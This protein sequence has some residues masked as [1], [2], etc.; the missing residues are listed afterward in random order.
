MPGSAHRHHGP[1]SPFERRGFRSSLGAIAL[2]A[3]MP[4]N[5]NSLG[6]ALSDAAQEVGSGIGTAVIRDRHAHRGAGDHRVAH[7]RLESRCPGA[8]FFHGERV[9]YAVLA[10]VAGL[11]AGWGA[12]TLTDSCA[13]EELP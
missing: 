9:T 10:A 13:T 8:S 5:R 3:A 12:L 7:W 1:T 2:I 11:V 6:T 4:E